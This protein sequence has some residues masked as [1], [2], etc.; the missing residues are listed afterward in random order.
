MKRKELREQ[1][2]K[3]YSEMRRW[4]KLDHRHYSELMFDSADGSVWADCFINE[5]NFNKYRSE[6]IQS[7]PLGDLFYLN[8]KNRPLTIS[9]RIEIITNYI[10]PKLNTGIIEE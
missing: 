2:E 1:V 5:G 10:I 8:T 4:N 7:V 9:E 6:T 3:E